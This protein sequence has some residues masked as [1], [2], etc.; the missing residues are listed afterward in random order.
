MSFF[1]EIIKVE[2]YPDNYDIDVGEI[3]STHFQIDIFAF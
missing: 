2:F 3:L 1:L